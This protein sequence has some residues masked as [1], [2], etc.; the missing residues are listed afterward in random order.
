[1]VQGKGKDS[2]I[3]IYRALILLLG[4][5]ATTFLTV[6]LS[7]YPAISFLGANHI[8][9]SSSGKGAQHRI[10]SHR[11]SHRVGDMSLENV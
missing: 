8:R 2:F 7:L 5:V 10:I 11:V 6:S 4:V 9:S 1:M 3:D